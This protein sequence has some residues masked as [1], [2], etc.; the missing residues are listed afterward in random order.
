[1]ASDEGQRAIHVAEYLAE[2]AAHDAQD[3]V[4]VAETW[5]VSQTVRTA[6]GDA[7]VIVLGPSSRTLAIDPVLRTPGLLDAIDATTPVLVV[8]HQDTA[9]AD[10]IRVSGLREPDPG[11][12]EPIAA[13]PDAV[14]DAARRAVR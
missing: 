14:L 2:P 1:V 5:S 13:N 10:L 3:V 8:E 6:L 9:P 7:D 4:L 12:A 11:K